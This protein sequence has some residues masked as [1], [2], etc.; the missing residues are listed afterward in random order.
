MEKEKN[1]INYI[2]TSYKS[3]RI[4]KRISVYSIPIKISKKY[5]GSTLVLADINLEFLAIRLHFLVR[6][7]LRGNWT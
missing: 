3:K 5:A 1:L 6:I 7:S 2:Q 4:P